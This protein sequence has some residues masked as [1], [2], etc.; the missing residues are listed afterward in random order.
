VDAGRGG[1]DGVSVLPRHRPQRH[2]DAVPR[3][4]RR[5]PTC[6]SGGTPRP[7]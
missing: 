5:E 1:V 7:R 3:I 4:G 2:D 6:S